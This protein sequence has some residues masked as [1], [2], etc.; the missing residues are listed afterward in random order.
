MK[1]RP[2]IYVASSWQNEYQPQFVQ[3]LRKDGFEVYDFRHPNKESDGFH[4]SSIDPNWK[5]WSFKEFI[6][7]GIC[8]QKSADGFLRDIS[9]LD[10]CDVCILLLPCGLSAHLEAGYAAGGNKY[11]II[12]NPPENKKIVPE[13]MYMMAQDACNDY[14]VL[15][16]HLRYYQKTGIKWIG[17][18]DTCTKELKE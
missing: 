13:L 18:V 17:K 10:I 1:N 2:R 12:Y 5:K 6:V 16:K 14:E 3:S 4:W 11:L 9:N 7:K 8:H 15:V